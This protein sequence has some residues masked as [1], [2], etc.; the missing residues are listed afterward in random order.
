[1]RFSSFQSND[2]RGSE[3]PRRLPWTEKY[4]PAAFDRI[5]LGA[6]N[7]ALFQNITKHNFF[8]NLLISGPGGNGKTSSA[9]ALIREYLV[10][11]S[12]VDPTRKSGSGGAFDPSR[13]MIMNASDD[14]GIDVIRTQI[15]QF[16][17]SGTMFSPSG[18]GNCEKKFVVLDEVDALTRPAQI[19][20]KL[21][22]QTSTNTDVRFCLICNYISK[23]DLSLR[24][25]F[26]CIRFDQ[27]PSTDV[28]A[29]VRNI[30][31]A[32]SVDIGDTEIAAICHM[33]RS[34]IRSMVNH[35]QTYRVDTPRAL[36]S[37][38]WEELRACM[39]LE[40]GSD[41]PTTIGLRHIQ[42]RQ[43][44]R[45]T[46]QTYQLTVHTLVLNYYTYWLKRPEY[47]T[48]AALSAIEKAMRT[49]TDANSDVLLDY[50][51]WTEVQFAA[52]HS[53]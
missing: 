28:C 9:L 49:P 8:P 24:R 10:K 35:L 22:I 38:V 44:L 46:L 51:I 4:R 43:T 37:D 6:T 11:Y 7:R 30:A 1:M 33:Y 19:A 41:A 52:L 5:V 29:F 40:P 42:L 26:M 21:I 13:V 53:T 32:E 48:P 3:P 39:T 23:L 50:F 34:D 47:C 15:S 31:E 45:S 17:Q 12:L 27:L 2:S 18:T 25:E 16:I 14:R 36:T 20:L